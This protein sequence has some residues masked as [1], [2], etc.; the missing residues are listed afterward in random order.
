[1]LLAS[2]KGIREALGFDDMTDITAAIDMALHAAEPQL[3]S[4]LDT[5]FER[6]EVVDTFWVQEPGFRQG[7]HFKTEF[8]LSRGLLA[9][10]PAV[11]HTEEPTLFSTPHPVDVSDAVVFDLG[12]GIGRDWKTRYNRHY[13]EIRYTAGFEADPENAQSY[14]LSQV[15][16]WLQEAAKLKCL[17]HL[18]KQ[19]ALTEA[20]VALD[21]RQLDAQLAALINRHIRYAPMALLPL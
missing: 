13:V 14:D 12:K 2:V 7:S 16:A 19:P 10:A 4:I 11:S 1:M 5:A 6:S 21:A 20:G 3:A 17:M 18:A 8:R 9:A 15:P